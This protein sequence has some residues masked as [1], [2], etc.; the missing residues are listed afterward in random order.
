MWEHA[1]YVNGKVCCKH[2]T[3]S[4]SNLAGST[5]TPLKHIRDMHYAFITQEQ[6]KNECHGIVKLVE[7]LVHLQEGP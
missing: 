1:I 7:H 2:C 5:S 3:K 6:K 4:W